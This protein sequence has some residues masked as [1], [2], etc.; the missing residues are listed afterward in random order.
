MVPANRKRYHPG[1]FQWFESV[2]DFDMGVFQV[3]RLLDIGVADIRDLTKL[4]G[5]Y[6]GR[7]VHQPHQR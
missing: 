6:P 4:V 5:P 3:V 1:G 7:L 2:L